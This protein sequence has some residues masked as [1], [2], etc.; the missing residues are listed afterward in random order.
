MRYQYKWEDIP[1]RQVPQENQDNLN[2]TIRRSIDVGINHTAL[3]AV[4]RYN[5]SN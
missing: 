5:S 2:A 1:K 4:M 3:T